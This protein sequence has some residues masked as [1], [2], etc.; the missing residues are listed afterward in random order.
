MWEV[1]IVIELKDVF[2]AKYKIWNKTNVMKF[3]DMKRKG[4]TYAYQSKKRVNK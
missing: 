2:G 1:V 3:I 4:Q